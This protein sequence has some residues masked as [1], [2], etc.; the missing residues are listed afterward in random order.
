M[1]VRSSYPQNFVGL[2]SYLVECAVSAHHSDGR[3]VSRC[4]ETAHSTTNNRSP[5]MRNIITLTFVC[6]GFAQSAAAQRTDKILLQGNSVG[7][8]TVQPQADG[9]VHAE[10]SYSDR[11]RGDHILATWKIDDD[12]LPVEYE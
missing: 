2:V 1:R 3:E 4:A 5:T 10:Y 9:S 8:Q 7:T 12:G 6:I 11:G